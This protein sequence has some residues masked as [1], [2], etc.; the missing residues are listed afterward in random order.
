MAEAFSSLQGCNGMRRNLVLFSHWAR[1]LSGRSYYHVPQHLGRA[2]HPS[3]LCGYFNDMTGKTNWRGMVDHE[4]I[5]MV[6]VIDGSVHCFPTTVVQKALGHYDRYVLT[7]MRREREEFLRLCGW[8]VKKQDENGGWEVQAIMDLQKPLKYSA[9]P[10]GEAISALVR[11]WKE[12]GSEQYF[13]AAVR[14]FELMTSPVDMEGTACYNE[15]GLRFEEYPARDRNTVLNGWIFALFGVYD[16]F[17]ATGRE[18]ARALFSMSF[19]TL[20]ETIQKF[21]AGFW[22]FYDERGALASPFYHNLHISQLEA[23]SMVTGDEAIREYVGKWKGYRKNRIN[24]YHALIL[25]AYQKLGTP[26]SV[27]VIK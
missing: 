20:R 16:F 25:K 9:M 15:D 27:V 23:L 4:G 8:L 7:G 6:R 14:A 12:T 13:E 17:L 1:M 19:N 10:Q 3:R 2:F 18:P 5:P 11:A 24:R 22:S 21:D 26:D